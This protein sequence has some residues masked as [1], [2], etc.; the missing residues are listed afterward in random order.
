MYRDQLVAL[1]GADATALIVPVWCIVWFGSFAIWQAVKR[2]RRTRERDEL[3]KRI[4]ARGVHYI[5]VP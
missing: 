4:K 2:W 3:I 1:I 5:N